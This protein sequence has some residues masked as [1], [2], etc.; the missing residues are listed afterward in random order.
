MHLLGV[1]NLVVE[2]DAK[3]VKGMLANPDIAPSASI[4]RWILGILMF[5]FTLVHVPGTHH[6]PDGL[7]RRRPQP[8]DDDEPDD[9]FE[10]WVDQ[11]NGF[12]HFIDPLPFQIDSISTSPPIS[13]YITDVA[14]EDSQGPEDA[15]Q[16]HSD[17]MPTPYTIVPRS[18]T[19]QVTD[20]KLT[21]V[22]TWLETLERPPSV[23][24]SWYKTF[25]RFCTEFFLSDG[26]L[27]RKDKNGHHKVVVSPERR[28]FL[29]SSAHNDVGH[30]GFYATN[31]L[32]V[33]RYWWP[34]M[35]QDIAWFLLTCH[36][37]QLRKTQ[38]VSIPPV[39]A[40][41]APLFSK[42][43]M[44]TMHLTPSGGY[45]Y[46]VQARCSLTHWPEWEMLRKESAK[47]I[48]T[49]ILRNIIYR[50]G[51]LLE[52]VTDN[53]APFV[54]ALS[55]LS[56]HYHITHIRISGYNSRANGL[57]ERSHFDVRQALFKACDGEESKWSSTA[58]SV[59]WAERVTVRRRMGC[60]PYFAT[61]GA[62]PLLPFDITEANY[63]L[64]PP[65]STLSSTDL[66]SR[67]AIALQKRR[68]QMAELRDKV[69]SARLEAAR[70]FEK[71]HSASIK[72]FNFKLG[73]L[74]LIRN[75]AIEKAL[76]R[77]MRARYLG[78]LI[79]ISRN[80]GGAYIVSEL[81]GSVFDR[82]VAAFR[83]IPYFARTS[84]V[85]PS[86]EDLVDISK[87]RLAEMEHSPVIDPDDDDDVGDL[88][89]D[90]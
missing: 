19:A 13:C 56:R 28:L 47:T 8:G 12:I 58:Y 88:L 54:K 42:V 37:C 45:K 41:P 43:Y 75:T 6:G 87:E 77:K 11:V 84:L 2:V 24:D 63:L 17:D 4:N 15:P 20:E 30:H 79:V 39:V 68:S 29:I 36:L 52:I 66:I 5:H 59:F 44:D 3:F 82:P 60:S 53:G 33:E 21:K 80:K 10:D 90:D 27:W 73:D 7:S 38:Q 32:L 50:W 69:H 1:R 14:R 67:R 62:H 16:V 18:D 46:I 89:L 34:G 70:R 83:V 65:D 31:A 85:L 22:K 81:D 48:A 40:Q 35:A 55:Y 57:V 23:S 78:P 25:M 26:R 61:T 72:D 86:L 9:D 49:F 71:D 64:P 74:V 51:T 76:N